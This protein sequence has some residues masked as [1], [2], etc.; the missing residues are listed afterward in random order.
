MDQ[1]VV[2]RL[3]YQRA[4]YDVY[5][6]NAVGLLSLRPPSMASASAPKVPAPGNR[7]TNE[8]GAAGEDVG[9]ES[10]RG[11]DTIRLCRLRLCYCWARLEACL[12]LIKSSL[13]GLIRCYLALLAP[14]ESSSIMYECLSLSFWGLFV[15]TR[16]PGVYR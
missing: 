2:D 9:D 16:S 10:R 12:L 3:D 7:R 14:V 6:R 15:P 13:L 4:S 11:V 1:F 5:N 8:S